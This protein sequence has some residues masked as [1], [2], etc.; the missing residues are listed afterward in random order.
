MNPITANI[1]GVPYAVVDQTTH[2][3]KLGGACLVDVTFRLPPDKYP[4]DHPHGMDL[5]NLLKRFF[6]ALQKTVFS[7]VPGGDGCVIEV[8]AR[9]VK[10]GSA[11]EAG[12]DLT[13]TPV[14]S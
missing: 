13:I 1:S 2:L 10:V 4:T 5:D 14:A 9:K 7:E 11:R 3:P 12:A 6:D 8:R